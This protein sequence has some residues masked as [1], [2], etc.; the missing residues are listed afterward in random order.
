VEETVNRALTGVFNWLTTNKLTLAAHKTEAVMLPTKTG[1][2]V[3][4]FTINDVRIEPN[5]SLK[6]LSMDQCYRQH[7]TTAAEKAGDTADALTGILPN[8]G[9]TK[10]RSRKLLGSVV[11]NQQLYA[12]PIWAGALVFENNI[13]TLEGPQRKVALRCAMA[14]RTVTTNAILVVAN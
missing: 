1:Y 11:M 7:L 14:Y 9:G 13:R 12:A 2:C 5:K 4:T 10:Q 6:Y 3:P 8:I